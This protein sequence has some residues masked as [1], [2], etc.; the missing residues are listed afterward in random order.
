MR[1]THRLAAGFNRLVVESG[2]R[3]G[4]IQFRLVGSY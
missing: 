4:G 3:K 2:F 1:F